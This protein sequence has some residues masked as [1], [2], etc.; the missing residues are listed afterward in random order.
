MRPIGRGQRELIIGDRQTGKT[1]IG[2]DTIINQRDNY[3]AG[4][5]VY[6]PL[7]STEINGECANTTTD[8]KTPIIKTKNF[9]ILSS[10]PI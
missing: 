9:F 8:I 1:A 10:Y 7:S 4:K 2:I 3:L 6:S 5:P